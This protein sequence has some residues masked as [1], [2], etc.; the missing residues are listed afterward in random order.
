MG[1]GKRGLIRS[2]GNGSTPLTRQLKTTDTHR[3][4]MSTLVCFG[5]VLLRISAP[6]KEVLLQSPSFAAHVGG[7]EANVAVGL[8]KFGNSAAVVTVLPSNALGH[9]C[10]GEL[11]RHNVDTSN[12]VYGDGRMGLYFLTHGAGHRPAEVL[13]DR[14]GSAFAVAPGNLIDWDVALAGTEW[15]HVSGI[16]PA[17][18]EGGAKAALRAVEAAR[19]AGVKI[20]YDCN[21]RSRLW[22]ERSAHAAAILRELCGYATLIFGDDRDIAFMLDFKSPSDSAEQRRRD[23]AAQAF[24]S[25]ATLQFIAYTERTRHAADVQQISGVL[26]DR[27]AVYTTKPYSLHG[28]VDRIG[29][30]DAY[31]AGL[32]HGLL[33]GMSLQQTV[34]F[35]AASAALKHSIPGDFNLVSVA[36]VKLLLSEV[37]TDV[38]R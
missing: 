37:Q 28:I 26:H 9:A 4:N 18:S 22:G 10:A 20:S 5:E 8:S 38:R 27:N 24:A 17:V 35:A 23:A 36:D 13:Y 7:A 31:A 6:G 16:T 3:S 1:P 33:N 32:L 2:S 29:A 15:L 14:A 25:F 12:V 30:G 11:R 34:D 19:N 21:F